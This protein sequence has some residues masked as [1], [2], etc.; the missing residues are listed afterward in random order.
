VSSSRDLFGVNVR[1]GTRL[2][3]FTVDYSRVMAIVVGSAMAVL[4]FLAAANVL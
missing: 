1:E 3:K 2:H 4:G